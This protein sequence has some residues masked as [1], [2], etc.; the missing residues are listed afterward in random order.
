MSNIDQ[1]LR[2]YTLSDLIEHLENL[3]YS[4]Q[5]I[6]LFIELMVLEVKD[7]NR[8]KKLDE[9]SK[10]FYNGISKEL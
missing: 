4:N 1:K 5:E 7:W 9:E 8:W 10:K 2:N 6:D 3:G